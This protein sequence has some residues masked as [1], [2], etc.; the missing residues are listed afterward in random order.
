MYLN[1]TITWFRVSSSSASS[2]FL[3]DFFNNK[4][5]YLANNSGLLLVF[6][7]VVVTAFVLMNF[8]HALSRAA[9]KPESFLNETKTSAL[10]FLCTSSMVWT[11]TFGSCFWYIAQQREIAWL[12]VGYV[13]H[14]ELNDTKYE[15]WVHL[16]L[17][18][19]HRIEQSP[20][21]LACGCV[22]LKL[23]SVLLDLRWNAIPMS[24]CVPDRHSYSSPVDSRGKT[25]SI[26]CY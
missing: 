21:R 9:T 1:T 20:Q 25:K 23:F 4:S 26:F 15:R 5:Q 6:L 10:Y 24:T 8:P 22:P 11:Y 14:F 16:H 7:L 2:G 13:T 12:S 18:Q 3:L 17:L 19:R